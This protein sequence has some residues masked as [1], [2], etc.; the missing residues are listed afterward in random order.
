[1]PVRQRI[2]AS[3]A[4]VCLKQVVGFSGSLP[5]RLRVEL[6]LSELFPNP[7]RNR[8]L[9]PYS[10][11]V[12]GAALRNQ[13]KLDTQASEPASAHVHS[14]ARRACIHLPKVST[15][16]GSCSKM[17][18]PSKRGWPSFTFRHHTRSR[19]KGLLKPF[20]ARSGTLVSP[21]FSTF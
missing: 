19:S 6:V 9:H 4:S 17:Q 16:V 7:T 1:M 8:K 13:Y 21:I 15:A 11:M 3:E 18:F 5:T 10:K 20:L 14:L 12:S 2:P